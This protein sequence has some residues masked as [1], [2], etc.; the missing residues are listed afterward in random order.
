MSANQGVELSVELRPVDWVTVNSCLSVSV[1]TN[2]HAVQRC[3]CQLL[4][5]IPAVST[6]KKA[7]VDNF[8][9]LLIMHDLHSDGSQSMRG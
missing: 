8:L 2:I 3:R 4:H 9:P 6:G 1:I 5:A 7:R